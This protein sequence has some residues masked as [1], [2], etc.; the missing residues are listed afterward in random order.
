MLAIKNDITGR[1]IESVTEI[2]KEK[3]AS[4]TG[5]PTTLQ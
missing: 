4:L 5:H 3:Q 1:G 2:L